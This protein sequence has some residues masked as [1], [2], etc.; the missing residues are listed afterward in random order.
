MSCQKFLVDQ[1]CGRQIKALGKQTIF[2]CRFKKYQSVITEIFKIWAKL[3]KQKNKYIKRILCL[4]IDCF[5]DF[6]I[7]EIGFILLLNNLNLL[8]QTFF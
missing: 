1:S 5:L 2:D 8:S 7:T 3:L 6:D 4:S